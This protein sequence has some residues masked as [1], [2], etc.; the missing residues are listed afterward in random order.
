M[1][2]PLR[3]THGLFAARRGDHRPD[4]RAVL[5][6]S[7]GAIVG[8][9]VVLWVV[10]WNAG[11]LVAFGASHSPLSFRVDLQWQQLNGK[12]VA[13]SQNAYQKADF[14]FI[15]GTVNEPAH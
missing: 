2:I 13:V 4:V 7:I 8:S 11:A 5:Y 14:R 9:N 1:L 6:Q 15:D 3:T 10:E 12:Q